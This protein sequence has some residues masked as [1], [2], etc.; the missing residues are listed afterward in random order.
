MSNK[1]LRRT[2]AIA[3]F[4]PGAIVDFP[5]PISLIHAGLDAY[6]FD[7]NN[8][9]LFLEEISLSAGIHLDR[10]EVIYHLYPKS[11]AEVKDWNSGSGFT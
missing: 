11:S 5:G 1:P 2:Q 8:P 7:P 6:S 4:G 9:D 10:K 3:P